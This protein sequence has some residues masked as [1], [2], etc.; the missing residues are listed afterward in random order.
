ME[1]SNSDADRALIEFVQRQI[2]TGTTR[3]VLPGHLVARGS[4]VVLEEIRRLCK[5]NS[6]SVEIK[7]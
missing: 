7:M 1:G 5:L 4:D 6:V 3:I 2:N